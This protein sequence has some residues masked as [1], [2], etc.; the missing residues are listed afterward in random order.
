MGTLITQWVIGGLSNF[1]FDGDF[2]SGMVV[3]MPSRHCLPWRCPHLLVR[4]VQLKAEREEQVSLASQAKTQKNRWEIPPEAPRNGDTAGIGE[5]Y[6][7]IGMNGFVGRMKPDKYGSRIRV[8]SDPS[9]PVTLWPVKHRLHTSQNDRAL[10]IRIS[11]NTY[12]GPGPVGY[13][14]HSRRRCGTSPDNWFQDD[15]L[16]WEGRQQR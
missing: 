11:M 7:Q 9:G 1:C 14:T 13:I 15:A 5:L 2:G 4:R 10:Y 12:Q 6:V 16:G 3:P 8:Q